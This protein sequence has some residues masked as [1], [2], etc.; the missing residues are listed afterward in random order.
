MDDRG[1]N[2]LQMIK[3]IYKKAL[4]NNGKYTDETIWVQKQIKSVNASV[5]ANIL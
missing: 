1:K 4:K 3:E 5:A 2:I